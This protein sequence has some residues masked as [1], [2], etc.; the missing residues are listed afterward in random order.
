[1]KI[2][3]V[4]EGVVP[5][6]SSI[7]NAWIDFSTMDSSIVAVVSDVVRDGEPVVG[8][9]FNSN[10]RYS[11]GEILRRRIVPRLLAADP[12][13]LLAEDGQLDPS[14]AWDVVMTN[15]KPGGH[16]ERSVAVGVIDM[17]LFDLAAKIAG[18]PLYRWLADR[19]G[20]GNPD[21][22]VFVYAAGGYY[23][24]GKTLRDL[25]EEMQRFLDQ[26]YRVV[27][28]KIGGA[29]LAEDLQRIEAVLEVLDGDGSRLA[30]DVNGRFDLAT[31]L[32]YGTA[33]EPYGLFWYEEIGDPLDYQLNA[34]VSEHY[35]GPIAT[36]E[37]LFSLQDARNLVRY[38]GMRPDRDY[39][40]VDPA[41]SYGLT[42]YLRIQEMLV[43]HGWSSRRCIPHGGH[44][45][46]LH[47]AAAL[48]LGGNESYPGE[49]QPT[50]GFAD[51]A[52]VENSYVGLTETPGIGFES[53]VAFYG[54]L[55]ALH[56]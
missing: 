56:A 32:E 7:R 33:I 50:G 21:E 5:I 49:F 27:K 17:A 35:R 25:Q 42:E 10:G 31:A 37:N 16:G 38:G 52:V 14:R 44:Q 6:S 2:V 20:D 54:V 18:Q 15:E 34:V 12:E 11:A 13:S 43:Q 45:F 53:K 48:K 4:H 29:D 47:I 24:P 41:L 9:G 22:K 28:M 46:S 26:G 55:R 23:A 19:Y 39:I 51:G 1:M 40:Q 3:S 30:V 36:G 8:Y